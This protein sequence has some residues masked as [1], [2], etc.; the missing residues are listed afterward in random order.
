MTVEGDARRAAGRPGGRGAAG[1]AYQLGGGAGRARSAVRSPAQARRPLLNEEHTWNYRRERW[2][3]GYAKY[4]AE[5]EV[6]KA[7][8]QGLEV[9]IVNPA[10]ILGAGD[11]YRQSSSLVVSGGRR[12][13]SRSPSPGA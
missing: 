6:Q 2:P 3:Y 13:K 11:L 1:G 7:V 10:Y 5:L 9:V 12:R 4:L 8:A